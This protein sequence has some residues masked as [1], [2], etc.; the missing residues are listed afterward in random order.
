[1][2][3]YKTQRSSMVDK[4]LTRLQHMLDSTNAIL[5]FIKGKSRK[6]LDTDRL[7]LSGIV[8]ELEILG[9]AAGKV[10][11]ETQNRFSNIPWKQ[12]IGMRNRLIHAYFNIDHDIIW[13]T[14]QDSLPPLA[15][16]LK[17]IVSNYPS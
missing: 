5:S 12:V 14:V 6:N 2:K 3:S 4:D 7:L 10:S 11:K 8:R 15:T 16:S 9:E 13:K 17:Q 1:M